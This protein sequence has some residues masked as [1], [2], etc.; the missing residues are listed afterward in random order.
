M[1]TQD[2]KKLIPGDVFPARAVLRSTSCAVM[3][4]MFCHMCDFVDAIAVPIFVHKN[5]LRRIAPLW[6][7]K[8]APPL[9]VFPLAA[10]ALMCTV[11]ALF[12]RNA[13]RSAPHSRARS[14][15]LYHSHKRARLFYS[16]RMRACGALG[17]TQPTALMRWDQ[18]RACSS[19]VPG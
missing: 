3:S 10:S 4:Q 6:V 1:S 13:A 7:A 9:P 8:C 2:A 18:M 5:D 11:S 12:G 19:T 17:C 15:A 14:V 16:K